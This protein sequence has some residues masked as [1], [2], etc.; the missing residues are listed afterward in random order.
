MKNK[1]KE[2]LNFILCIN[3]GLAIGMFYAVWIIR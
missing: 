2:I 1:T 3:F